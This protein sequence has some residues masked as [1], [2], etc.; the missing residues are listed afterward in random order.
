MK[1]VVSIVAVVVFALGM[2]SC[3]ND[4]AS[5][6][7]LYDTLEVTASDDEEAHDGSREGGN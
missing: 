1:K 4:S 5:N 6:D 2:V 7:E 3:T